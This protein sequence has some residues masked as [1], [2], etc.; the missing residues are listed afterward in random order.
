[1]A[2]RRQGFSPDRD[3]DRYHGPMKVL[4]EKRNDLG[5]NHKRKVMFD[6]TPAAN[7][8]AFRDALLA[9]LDVSV[10]NPAAHHVSVWD[11]ARQE[12][13]PL[14]RMDQLRPLNKVRIDSAE[15]AVA[16][17]GSVAGD[18]PHQPALACV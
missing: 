13:V 10:D 15:P 16:Q 17:N 8:A 11:A 5:I 4:V 9:K 12:F 1:M 3:G 2:T 18:R 7:P 6:A 14:R